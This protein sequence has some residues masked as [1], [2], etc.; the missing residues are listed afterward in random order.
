MRLLRI[1]FLS[2]FT[3]VLL[4]VLLVALLGP[5][6]FVA[7]WRESDPRF[8]ALG[9]SI[10]PL[11]QAL[12]AHK[13]AVLLHAGGFP[14]SF[15]RALASNLGGMRLG[16]LTPGRVGDAS[17]V[18]YIPGGDRLT[19]LGLFTLDRLLDFLAM[20]LLATIGLVSTLHRDAALVAGGLAVGGFL[21]LA[22]RRSGLARLAAVA[23][24][25]FRPRLDPV[26]V[27]L[28][29]LPGG[30]LLYATYLT[31]VTQVALILQF[32]IAVRAFD[33]DVP[34][35]A[36][37]VLPLVL[38]SVSI[39]VGVGGIGVKEGASVLFLAPFGVDGSAAVSGSLVLLLFGA[40][41]AFLSFPWVGAPSV[42]KPTEGADL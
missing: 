7:A 39:P 8:L 10:M 27:A 30:R 31:V 29:E 34:V 37:V 40:L 18:L 14:V 17:R 36:A 1:V 42:G 33:P 20:V 32:L 11:H 22:A 5:A 26:V 23:P 38:L 15:G 19:L 2:R 16:Y 25:R 24:A 12:R 4:L 41:P 3:P 9:F 21:L 28:G 6:R 13:W 35:A